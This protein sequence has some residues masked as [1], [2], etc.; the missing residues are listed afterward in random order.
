MPWE[1]IAVA[2]LPKLSRKPGVLRVRIKLNI[3]KGSVGLGILTPDEKDFYKQIVSVVPGAQVITLE[4]NCSLEP[5]PII[6]RH[7][8][9]AAGE[10]EFELEKLELEVPASEKRSSPAPLLPDRHAVF[11]KFPSWNGEIPSGYAVN[12]VGTITKPGYRGEPFSGSRARTARLPLP[13]IGEE[14]FEWIDLLEAVADARDSFTMVELGAGWGRWL[15]DA[16]NALRLI[17]KA[18]L[19]VKLVGVEAEP[20]HFAWMKEHFKNNGLDLSQHSLIEAA[21]MASDGRVAFTVGEASG[22]YGQTALKLD[23][24]PDWLGADHPGVSLRKVEAISLSTVLDG[25]PFVDLVD[26]DIQG[27]EA[28]VVLASID[29]LQTRVR[30]VHIA[31]HGEAIEKSLRQ[32]FRSMGWT[33]RW[34]FSLQGRRET[35]YGA[36]LFDDGVQGW[37][38]PRL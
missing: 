19:C 24:D 23:E 11:S 3:R 20:Q 9:A 27:S 38:N 17:N 30:R 13:R 35:P 33:C 7:G 12:W 26:M 37:I 21:I 34:D 18:E 15:V 10:T 22:W 4:A 29:L 5:G 14:Y 16:W 31:T 2:V 25:I 6:F 36:V 8:C 28:E 1:Y 32:A